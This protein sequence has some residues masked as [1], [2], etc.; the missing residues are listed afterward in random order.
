MNIGEPYLMLN[1]GKSSAND[2]LNKL[3]RPIFNHLGLVVVELLSLS[4]LDYSK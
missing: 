1:H 2:P 4:A 3:F